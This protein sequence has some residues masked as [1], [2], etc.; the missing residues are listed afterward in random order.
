MSEALDQVVARA[1]REHQPVASY[2]LCSG[3]HDSTV[4]AHRCRAF[5]DELVWL[6]TGTAVPG[7]AEFV[8]E[9][10]A[11]LGKPLR[12]LDAGD[13]FRKMVLGDLLWW[14]RYLEARDREPDVS[15]ESFIAADRR[16]YGRAAGGDL[17][18]CPY[19]FPGPG[20]HGRAYAR[21]KERQLA[22]L[23]AGASA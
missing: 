9:F 21:L 18:Q 14:A 7:V 20:A 13:A 5:Y 8:S 12:V 4:L 22:R 17:G 3:G 16:R 2:C 23:Q 19:G 10:A 15:V 1:R 11:W 6:D